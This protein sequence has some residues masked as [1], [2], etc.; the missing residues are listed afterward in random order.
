M[1]DSASDR[2]RRAIPWG[3]TV[4]MLLLVA[5][6]GSDEA[7][8]RAEGADPGRRTEPTFAL[9]AGTRVPILTAVTAEWGLDGFRSASALQAAGGLAAG[10]LDG[11]GRTDLAVAAGEV[12]IFYG[13]VDGMT[14]G[15][16]VVV[17][18]GQ[19]SSV[20]IA[21]ID[22]DGF[23]D[24]LVGVVGG[25]DVILWGDGGRVDPQ[26]AV[27]TVLSGGGQTVGLLPADLDGDGSIDVLRISHSDADADIVWH[28]ESPRR[29]TAETLPDSFRRSFAAEIADLD[30]D[31][32][33]DLW[34]TRDIGWVSG[35]DSIYLRAVDGWVDVAPAWNADLAIDGMGVAL[36]DLS[37]DG[38][39]DAYVT[40]IG[41]NDVLFWDGDGYGAA[42][43][44]GAGRIRPQEA[45]LDRVSSSWAVMSADL[46]LDGVLDLVVA[47]GGFGGADIVNKVPGTGFVDRDTPAVFL[48][49]GGGRFTD[50]WPSLGLEFEGRLRGLVIADFDLDGD[51]D[52]VMATSDRG[53]LALR[54]DTPGGSVRLAASDPGCAA[55]F[56]A[57]V[58][59]G[60]TSYTGLLSQHPFLGGSSAEVIVGTNGLST[61][62]L[63]T[64]PG[65]DPFEASVATSA[66]RVTLEVPCAEETA[67]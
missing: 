1:F 61:D 9:P 42:A 50:V 67:G 32:E 8:P 64:R 15:S 66:G 16:R 31:G 17:D 51:A 24:L 39:L 5:A 6:C 56:V 36:A 25:D 47:N 34:V 27:R 10:D 3:V 48:G 19:A 35:P 37:G 63:V 21:D 18:A 30:D 49:I 58:T 12:Q 43:D 45:P 46:N 13:R 57:T 29:F 2:V 11:D 40:D 23:S 22:G 59:S 7:D 65:L 53:L 62:V 20:A 54:N 60:Q 33:L 28:H 52:I 41:E 55:G 4:A 44:T 26:D 14:A 38:Q